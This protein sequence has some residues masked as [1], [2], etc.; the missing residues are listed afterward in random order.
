MSI[1]A[2][3]HHSPNLHFIRGEIIEISGVLTQAD[4]QNPHTQ[5]ASRERHK[6]AAKSYG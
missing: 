4:W 5:L 6:T 1:S 2:R 3:G